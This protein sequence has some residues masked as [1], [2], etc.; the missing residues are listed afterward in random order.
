MEKL[1]IWLIKE[2]ETLPVT[3]NARLMRTGMMAK[4][5]AQ[6]R[7]NVVWWSST[8]AHG[9]KKYINCGQKEF[10]VSDN[11]KL[12]LLHSNIVYKKNMSLKRALYQKMIAEEFRKQSQY[13]TK[14]DVIVCS[15][16]LISFAREAV[17]YGKEN[18]VPVIIDIRD[19]WPDIYDRIFPEVI[20]K[21]CRW[22]L[23]P[24][25][26]SAK[27][28]LKSADGIT[29]ITMHILEWGCRYAGREP[30][31]NDRC[32]FLG[33]ETVSLSVLEM[34]KMKHFWEKYDINENTWNI[35]FFAS[36]ENRGFDLDTVI[37]AVIKIS[38]KFKN[39]RFII[40]GEGGDKNRFMSLAADSPNIIFTGWLDNLQMNSLMKLSKL[41]I[42]CMRNRD[43][44]KD[45]F[46]NKAIQ[47]LSAGI[48]VLNALQGFAKHYLYETKAG[49]T[50]RENDV[51]DCA[52]KIEKLYL[53]EDLRRSM[54]LNAKK[55]FD[56]KYESRIVNKQYEEYIFHIVE[57]YRKIAN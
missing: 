49:L 7:H 5:L 2:G 21:Y 16:P 18:H 22:M 26:L 1:N 14:P 10:F 57:S 55:E 37:K 38:K 52:E 53:N 34:E 36:L 51:D 30:G 28:I 46:S 32:I 41:G 35:C 19:Q 24:M 3:E 23:V 43:D 56:I 15:W 31:K 50:Y 25:K 45:T 48:P 11:E 13:Q 6:Q 9:I 33:N 39:I 29:G 20:R 42:Y 17:R 12:I 40:G 47:Y 44:F 54:G 8:Y 27:N 4:Y